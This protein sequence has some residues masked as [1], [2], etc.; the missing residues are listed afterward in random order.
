MVS[1][2]VRLH[3]KQDQSRG[4]RSPGDPAGVAPHIYFEALAGRIVVGVY[5]SPRIRL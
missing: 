3:T 2:R 5:V 4:P 1:E